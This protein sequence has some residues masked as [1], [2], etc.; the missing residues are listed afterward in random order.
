MTEETGT[1]VSADRLRSFIERIE[2]LSSEKQDIADS[3]KEV[4]AESKGC[5]FDPRIIRIVV[6]LRK[7][8]AADRAEQEELVE[9][10]ARAVGL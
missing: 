9:L 6:R 5:G 1:D 3:I 4:Y 10:Y 8:E 2:K 7:M